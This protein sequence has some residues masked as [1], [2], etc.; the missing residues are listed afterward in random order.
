MRKIQTMGAVG[1]MAA[2]LLAGCG[3]GSDAA[4][5]PLDDAVVNGGKLVFSTS[6]N[7]A[8][9][10]FADKSGKVSGYD[11]EVCEEI[12]RRLDLKPEPKVVT[13]NQTIAGVEAGQYDMA[14]TGVALTPERASSKSFKVTEPTGVGGTGV[15]VLAK[16][17]FQTVDDLRGKR[18]GEASGASQGKDVEAAVDGDIKTTQ[19]PGSAEQ[20]LALKSGRIDAMSVN[21]LVAAY[22]AKNDDELRALPP[23]NPGSQVQ[24]VSKKSQ[25]LVDAVNDA[26]DQMWEDGTLGK[27]QEKYFG[28]TQERPAS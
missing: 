10:T 3:G 20:I 25:E 26:I 5:G 4:D 23:I 21:A 18:H 28:A 27:L 24:I 17:S 19:Y 15:L 8:P 22:Y 13:F 9:F 16:S 14:C 2:A 11:V 1:I 6:G 12:A 7:Y